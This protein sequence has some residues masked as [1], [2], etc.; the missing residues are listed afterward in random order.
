MRAEEFH[1]DAELGGSWSAVVQ[2]LADNGG[3]ALQLTTPCRLDL[4]AAT[5]NPAA[6]PPTLSVDAVI[7]GDGKSARITITANQITA[8]GVGKFEQ[9]LTIGDAVAGPQVMG[10]GW[11]VVRGRVS[12][13]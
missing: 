2:R 6:A 10:R 5:L 7:S 8:L 1:A 3:S 13:L 4:W 12:D 9:R 11:F